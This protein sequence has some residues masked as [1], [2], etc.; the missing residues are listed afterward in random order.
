MSEKQLFPPL[1]ID[2]IIEGITTDSPIQ[3]FHIDRFE[4]FRQVIRHATF[5]H[6]H[7]FYNIILFTAGSGR[8]RIDFHDY[9]IRAGGTFFL[10]PGQIHSWELSDDV[11]GYNI[12]FSRNFIE[13][14]CAYPPLLELPYFHSLDEEPLLK[15]DADRIERPMHLIYEEFRR[16]READ[17]NILRVLTKFLL[18]EA[19]RAF[20]KAE[21][22]RSDLFRQFERLVDEHFLRLR[23]PSDY[24]GLLAITSN[25]LN[26][27]CKR[28]TGKTAGSLIRERLVL[29]ACRLLVHSDEKIAYIADQLGFEEASY[30]SRFFRK[31]MGR[32]PEAFRTENK[33]Q[34]NK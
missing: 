5:P 13:R 20:P 11:Q 22:E 6:R 27:L 9:E 23:A 1:R 31:E 25:Y 17:A 2:Q 3:D 4:S 21:A 10:T 8:H 12:L 34:M 26:V 30:F 33:S 19:A 18:L 32:S 7:D 14:N 24:A 15:N 29:E 16:G 28:R